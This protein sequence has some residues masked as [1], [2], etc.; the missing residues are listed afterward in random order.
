VVSESSSGL[1]HAALAELAGLL[2]AT[3]SFEQLMQRIAELAARTV[4]DAVTC[5]ITLSQDGHVVTVAS[6]DPLARLLDEQQYELDQGPCLQA[7][8]TGLV[9]SA[10]DLSRNSGGAATR[11][12][13]WP[14]GSGRSIRARCWS[15]T[16][17]SARSTSIR[18]GPTPSTTRPG[19]RS[20]S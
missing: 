6:A 3:R 14:T 1:T 8:N 5:G 4:P 9:V 13:H 16:R 7:L 12:G 11:P 10:A 18:S 19:S 17:R 15:T 2:M 20:R